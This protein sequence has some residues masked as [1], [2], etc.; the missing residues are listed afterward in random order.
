LRWRRE[1]NPVN[2]L[3]LAGIALLLVGT[4][5]IWWIGG[6]LPSHFAAGKGPEL[7]LAPMLRDQQPQPAFEMVIAKNLFSPDR[8]APAPKAAKVENSLEGSHLLGTMII[9]VTR[10]AIIE[11][12]TRE[13]GRTVPEVEVV[14]LGDEWSGYKVVEIS[15]ESV[16][17]QGKDGRKTLSFPE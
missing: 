17:F 6:G 11:S 7:P 8:N 16:T 4:I 5:R 12:K 1:L 15:N 2:L 3:L 10:A 13:R 14:Y 9:G